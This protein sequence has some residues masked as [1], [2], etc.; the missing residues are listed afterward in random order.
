MPAATMRFAS[1]RECSSASRYV[2]RRS[3]VTMKSRSPHVATARRS[4]SGIVSIGAHGTCSRGHGSSPG[5]R[6]G[7][8]R[9]GIFFPSVEHAAIDVMVQRGADAA[10]E[11]FSWAWLPQSWSHDALTLLAVI[12]REVPDIELGTAV[13]PIYP[14][15]PMMLAAQ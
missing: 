9:I 4:A 6:L 1:R 8:V 15:H 7:P 13:V 10:A 2:M 5:R 3:G 11:G 12:G 14:R